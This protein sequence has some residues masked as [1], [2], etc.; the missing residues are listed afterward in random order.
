MLMKFFIETAQIKMVLIK[1]CGVP[2]QNSNY[3]NSILY[4]LQIYRNSKKVW[5]LL[6][7]M[8]NCNDKFW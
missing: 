1:P 6:A 8:K 3:L 4:K 2:D 7:D 5:T